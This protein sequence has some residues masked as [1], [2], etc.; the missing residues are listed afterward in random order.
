M[1]WVL[2][3]VKQEN[4][5]CRSFTLLFVTKFFQSVF[6][7]FWQLAYG[8][9]TERRNMFEFNVVVSALF[10]WNYKKLT[11]FTAR[12]GKLSIL[13]KTYIKWTFLYFSHINICP[14]SIGVPFSSLISPL[15]VKSYYCK[16]NY[17]SDL[18]II[19]MSDW[20]K[21]LFKL[22]AIFFIALYVIHKLE[23]N[24]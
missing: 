1:S 11:S 2:S 22:N 21:T 16:P 7:C 6:L 8:Q 15:T 9:S 17:F 23:R 13:T 4:F 10:D 12:I 20:K 3:T 24:R 19:A 14:K 18:T 5:M